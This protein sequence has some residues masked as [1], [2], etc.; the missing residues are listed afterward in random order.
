MKW[1][2]FL[3]DYFTFS[4]KERIGLLTVILIIVGIWIF[5]KVSRPTKPNPLSADT[6]W[7]TAAKEL[8]IRSGDSDTE[9]ITVTGDIDDLAFART[10]NERSSEAKPQFFNFDPNVL[11]VENWQKLGV[12]EKTI[13][14]IQNYL[15]K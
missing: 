8:M 10:V 14:T 1:K 13:A 4:R 12:R 15:H 2:E 7:I 11:A 3:Q 9:Q 6:S 5:P